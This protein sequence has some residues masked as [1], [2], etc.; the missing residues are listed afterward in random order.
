VT[1]AQIDEGN[2]LVTSPA[3]MYGDA[4]VHEV[5]EGIGRMVEGVLARAAK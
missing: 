4:P 2:K 5:F 1:G 3:Y